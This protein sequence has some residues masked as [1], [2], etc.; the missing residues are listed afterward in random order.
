MFVGRCLTVHSTAGLS[1]VTRIDEPEVL[2]EDDE[3]ASIFGI[4]SVRLL[5]LRLETCPQV[6][7]GNLGRCEVDRGSRTGHEGEGENGLASEH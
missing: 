4:V 3:A 1:L 6:L 2:H 7:L 5:V